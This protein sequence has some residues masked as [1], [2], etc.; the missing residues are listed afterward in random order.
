MDHEKRFSEVFETLTNKEVFNCG[1]GGEC[2]PLQ[3]FLTT[4]KFAPIL[5]FDTCF[6]FLFLPKDDR[7]THVPDPARYRPYLTD[8]GIAYTRSTEDM[9]LEKT[10]YTRTQLFF[11]QYSYTYHL[12]IYFKNRNFLK[13]ETLEKRYEMEPKKYTYI[14]KVID[15]YAD[16]FPDKQ[17]YFIIFPSLEYEPGELCERQEKNIRI[18]DL[19]NVLNMRSDYLD[20]NLHWNDR[21]HDKVARAL[22]ESVYNTR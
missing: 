17:L 18:I 2:G 11:L 16:E 7:F 15:M 8:T 1:M 22:Y 20:C 3:Y 13:S 21:G 10:L 6:V 12:L 5:N 9:P 14:D 19:T 4:K